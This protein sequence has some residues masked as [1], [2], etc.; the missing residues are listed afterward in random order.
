[1]DSLTRIELVSAIEDEFSVAIDETF[2]TGQTTVSDLESRIATRTGPAPILTRYPRWPLSAWASTLR[3]L[4]R[5]ILLESWLPLLCRLHVR[6]ANR[7]DALTPPL[8]FMANHGSFLD[9]PVAIQAI[10]PRFR[11]RLAIAA[12]TDV[13]YQRFQPAA[14]LADL[15][16]NSYPLPTGVTEN[17]RSGLE[18]TGRLLDDG[19]NVLIYPEGQLN[20]STE[21]LQPLKAGAGMLAVEMQVP[22][23][24]MI[25]TGTKRILPPDTLW[26][27]ARGVAQV[28]FGSP[29]HFDAGTD[30]LPASKSIEAALTAMLA[31]DARERD[32]EN[33]D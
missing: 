2:I 4:V 15:A 27:R 23:V 26:P 3:P 32:P 9:S 24:P 30:Y 11:R 10:P 21:K 28:R 7:L 13:L 1:V 16:F 25:I 8:I 19:W 14:P 5:G 29:L 31:E 18:Y 6:G 20:R 12:A 17:I 22:V 33:S